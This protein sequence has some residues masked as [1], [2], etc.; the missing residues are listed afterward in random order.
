MGLRALTE[1][2]PAGIIEIRSIRVGVVALKA[3]HTGFFVA[4]SRRGHLYGS[5]SAW[6]GWPVVGRHWQETGSSGLMFLT[7]RS[8]STLLTVGSRS[9]LR[10]TAT[11][12]MP[13]FAGVTEAG[14]CSWRWTGGG[15]LDAVAG[16]GDTSFPLISCPSW[17]PEAPRGHEEQL[18]KIQ[19][20]SGQVARDQRLE[21]A[22]AVAKP[23]LV[24]HS[25]HKH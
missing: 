7:P 17:S 13:H 12:P 4:M 2:F 22:Q 18:D 11:T 24:T 5:V 3:V 20:T 21:E 1:P 16:H 19:K 23:C 8:V 15:S 10:R 25:F 6:W 14:P 9:A